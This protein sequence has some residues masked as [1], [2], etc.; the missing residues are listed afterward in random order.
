MRPVTYL[1]HGVGL[2]RPHWEALFATPQRV[3][4]VELLVDN[5]LGRGGR[6]RGVVERARDTWPT[7]LHGVALSIGGPDPLDLDYLD[8]VAELA[9]AAGARWYTDHLCWSSGFG[10][11]YHDLI[12][13]PA[14]RE[15][16]ERVVERVRT[17]QARLDLPFGL[18]NPSVY[19]RYAD[20]E[21]SEAEF[22][23]AVL[24]G[25]DCGL[26]LDVNNV[27][28][29]SLN[30]GGD[31]RDVIAALPLERVMQIHLAGHGRVGDV[32]ID[33]HGAPMVDPVLDLYA[34]TLARTGPV[35]TLIE[36][37]NDLPPAEVLLAESDRARAVAAAVLGEIP[38]PCRG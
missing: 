33:T 10:V 19:V 15:A 32:V 6:T 11:E 2:R 25:A 30:H 17:V 29:N 4:F 5:A 3:D 14:T 23:R 26:L 36:W 38:V 27:Y 16:V 24:E 18:E 31:P 34:Y 12:P 8:R 21:L 13:L 7:V 9:H 35:S 22:L 1:G 20:D 37:D 28:V